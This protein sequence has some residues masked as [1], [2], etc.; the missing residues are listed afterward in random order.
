MATAFSGSHSSGFF[1][2]ALEVVYKTLVDADEE[3][4]DRA[5]AASLVLQQTQRIFLKN[6]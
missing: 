3:L 5:L 1:L 6:L 2:G 4:L